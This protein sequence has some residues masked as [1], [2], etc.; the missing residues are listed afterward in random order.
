MTPQ[1]IRSI[2]WEPEDFQKLEPLPLAETLQARLGETPVLARTREQLR[3]PPPIPSLA[4]AANARV[5]ETAAVAD[6][7]TADSRYR[8]LDG[9]LLHVA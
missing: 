3:R 1:T 9:K 7:A 2:R 5:Q 4:T 6:R 8:K